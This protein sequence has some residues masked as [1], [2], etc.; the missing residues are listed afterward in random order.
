MMSGESWLESSF[1]N[2]ILQE[3]LQYDYKHMENM[4]VYGYNTRDC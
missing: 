1:L 4:L 3:A 2:S